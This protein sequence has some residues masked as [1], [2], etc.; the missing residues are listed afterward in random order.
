MNKEIFERY[1]TIKNKIKD[2]TEEAK[3]IEK[4]VQ[5]EMVKEEADSIKSPIGTFSIVRRLRWIY[6]DK[7]KELEVKLKA[8]KK[9]EEEDGTATSTESTGLMFR[10]RKEDEK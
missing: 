4:E 6:S 7:V 1:A 8:T 2:L 9:I 3:L 10:A 5:E